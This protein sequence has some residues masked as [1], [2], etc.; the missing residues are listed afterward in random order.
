MTERPGLLESAR[1]AADALADV[2]AVPVGQL[3]DSTL[4]QLAKGLEDAGRL[5][6]TARCL[7]AAEITERSN[8]DFGQSGLSA[9]NGHRRPQH[10]LEYLTG[11]AAGEVA[12]RMKLG[13][14]I[15]PRTSFL[16]EP[17]EPTYPR[18]SEAML[19]GTISRDAAHII[20]TELDKAV[21]YHP[22]P[23]DAAIAERELVKEAANQPADL[24]AI[25]AKVWRNALDP[26]GIEPREEEIRA[27][28]SL[29]L[30]RESHGLIPISGA[31][32]P[33]CAAKLKA[34]FSDANA[35]G[36]M[37]RFLSLDEQEGATEVITN[38]NGEDVE[39]VK[40]PRSREQRQHDVLD[41]LLTAGLRNVGS[42]PGEMRPITT[43]TAI[44]HLDDLVDGPVT[45]EILT[46]LG[47]PDAFIKKIAPDSDTG[48]LLGGKDFERDFGPKSGYGWIDE[49]EEP[50]SAPTIQTLACGDE[51][52]LTIFDRNGAILWHGRTKRYFTKVQLKALAARDGG[53]I[54]C[55]AP[56]SWCDGH[57]VQEWEADHGKTDVSNGVL[58]CPAHHYWIHHSGFQ[59]AMITG[60]PY[61]RAPKNIDP[62]QAWKPV[63]RNRIH[64]T[65]ALRR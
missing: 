4:V 63:R 20:T 5:I 35:P 21:K 27:R 50:V 30:G 42:E 46:T 37:P 65:T 33:T 57:H 60:I 16:G 8:W 6:D 23:T 55:G 62:D 7:A 10:F 18:V 64:A 19:T 43:V 61:L 32:T 56:A 1:T 52:V 3:D 44:I 41:G 29:N 24:V 48:S 53:C 13:A 36:V 49:I 58:L 54:F 47:V 17:L 11:A 28:R 39:V 40:D 45:P 34:A 31:L 26:D 15:R 59:L 51:T 22:N 2:L 38:E 12:K 25:Q 14:A 9:K